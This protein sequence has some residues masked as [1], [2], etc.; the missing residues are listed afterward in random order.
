METWGDCVLHVDAMF[1]DWFQ[2]TSI[3]F[4]LCLTSDLPPENSR[5]R[6]ETRPKA[7]KFVLCVVSVVAAASGFCDHQAC[8][9]IAVMVKMLTKQPLS[10]WYAHDVRYVEPSLTPNLDTSMPP[11]SLKMKQT[12]SIDFHQFRPITSARVGRIACESVNSLWCGWCQLT[13]TASA[14]WGELLSVHSSRH[15]HR[16]LGSQKTSAIWWKRLD[17]QRY[18][19]LKIHLLLYRWTCTK[20]CSPE[21]RCKSRGLPVIILLSHFVTLPSQCRLRGRVCLCASP[22]QSKLAT[23]FWTVPPQSLTFFLGC[24]RG[25]CRRGQ[26]SKLL[27]P[28]MLQQLHLLSRRQG[29]KLSQLLLATDRKQTLYLIIYV[30]NCTNNSIHMRYTDIA[31]ILH[32]KYPRSESRIKSENALSR[33]WS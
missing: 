19:S 14:R 23:A 2:S 1:V 32:W 33:D 3:W 17:Y 26:L 15:R 4:V 22:M 11:Q 30:Q 25:I 21:Q 12:I 7:L 29:R 13:D 31:T 9:E 27:Y 10:K 5:L 24:R 8:Q 20:G 28:V 18:E 16:L 6:K